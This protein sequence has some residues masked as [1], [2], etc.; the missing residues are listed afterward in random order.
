MTIKSYA[1]KD[2][3]SIEDFTNLDDWL[4]KVDSRSDS[5]RLE[6][7][8]DDGI[9]AQIEEWNQVLKT[10]TAQ[11]IVDYFS[12]F[13]GLYQL[14]S[15]G[16]TGL[17]ILDLQ[18]SKAPI[19]FIN[20]LHLFPE[21]L[22]LVQR[23]SNRYKVDIHEFQ[24]MEK[25][26]YEAYFGPELYKRDEDRYDYIVKVLPAHFAYNYL[27]VKIVFTGR[28]RSQG[29]DREMLPICEWDE[30]NGIIKV[31]PLYN[32]TF[33]QVWDYLKANN[34]PYNALHDQG[35]KSIGDQHSTEK[36]KNGEREGRWKNREKTECGLHQDYFSK[37][38]AAKNI[39]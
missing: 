22:E 15:F 2:I 24:I 7:K 5:R 10:K 6:A 20:T 8:V 34:V 35:Y 19:V 14:S 4:Q 30:G 32:W 26:D 1:V 38:I 25:S 36:S 37:K 28:R 17:V 23:V 13:Q 29:N 21:T 18:K 3:S 9:G 11:E 31:N 33:D 12:Q 16:P 39:V 27:N